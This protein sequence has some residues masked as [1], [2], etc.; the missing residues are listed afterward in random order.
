VVREEFVLKISIA[1]RIWPRWRRFCAPASRRTRRFAI[2]ASGP[3]QKV[4]V[5]GIGGLGHMGIKLAK[6]MGA[7]S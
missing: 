7:Q 2:M 1:S 3:G 6:A 4:G 5:V